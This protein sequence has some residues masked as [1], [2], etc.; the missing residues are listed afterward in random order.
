MA[1]QLRPATLVPPV[2]QPG[3]GQAKPGWLG[4]G[5]APTSVSL[6]PQGGFI[7]RDGRR[8]SAEEVDFER[9]RNAAMM[10][11]GSDFSPI[12]HW[13]QG[14]ARVANGL[15]GGMNQRHLEKRLGEQADAD[16]LVMADLMKNPA[17]NRIAQI[18]LDPNAPPEAREYAKMQFDVQNRKPAQPHYFE[19]NDGSLWQVNPT[20]G[21]PELVRQDPTPKMNFIPDGLGG[22]KWAAVPGTGGIPLPT[23]EPVPAALPTGPVGKLTP[24]TGGAPSQGGANFPGR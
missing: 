8:M 13:T 23:E 20:T 3:F 24:I 2:Q 10:Q 9:R 1:M 5:S 15:I 17:S 6:M 11:A 19:S 12:Q 21:Q 14:L 22:G 18:L 4:F 7:W 16:R